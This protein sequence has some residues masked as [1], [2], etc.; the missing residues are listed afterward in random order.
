MPKSSRS[1]PSAAQEK[2]F[3]FTRRLEEIGMFFAKRSPQHQTMRRLARRLEKA[4]VAYA[5]LGGMALNAHRYERTTKDVDFLLT[6]EGLDAFRRQ[7]AGKEYE[8]VQGRPRRFTDTANGVTVDILV[9]G[10]FPGTGKPGP[11]AFP[12]PSAVSEVIDKLPVVNLPTLIQLKLAARRWRD[13][14]DV[15]ELIRVHD[16]DESF[17]GRLHP[18]VHQDFIECREEKRREDEYEARES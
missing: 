1:K 16:L 7:F 18:S 9:T 13:F 2:P 11:I 12:D 17:L 4:K 3:S 8:Q 14:A 15:V 10:L 5:I 6:A